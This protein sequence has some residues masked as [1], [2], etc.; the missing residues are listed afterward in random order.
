M[1]IES[2]VKIFIRSTKIDNDK[3]VYNTPNRPLLSPNP[4][5]QPY[6]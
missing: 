3:K 1:F 2:P 5:Q 4:T 6:I